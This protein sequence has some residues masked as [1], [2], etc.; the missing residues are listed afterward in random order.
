MSLSYVIMTSNWQSINNQ[1]LTEVVVIV[2]DNNLHSILLLDN[3]N[4]I[5]QLV[6]GLFLGFLPDW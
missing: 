4:G 3:E 5:F 6:R 2:S 1:N